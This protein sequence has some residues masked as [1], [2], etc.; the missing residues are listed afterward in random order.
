[1]DKTLQ[2]EMEDNDHEFPGDCVGI[3]YA[4]KVMKALQ[5]NQNNETKLMEEI[6]DQIENDDF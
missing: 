2:F 4:I 5:K 3:C 6:R 1:M